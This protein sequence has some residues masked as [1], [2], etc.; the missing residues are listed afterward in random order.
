V[1]DQSLSRALFNIDLS[2]MD[3]AELD[4]A[5]A[6]IRAEPGTPGAMPPAGRRQLDEPDKPSGLAPSG[7]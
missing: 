4:L 2:R 3:R 7:S 1:L 6:R 5:V